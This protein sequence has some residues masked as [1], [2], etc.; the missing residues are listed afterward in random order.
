M[1]T[2]PLSN[3]VYRGVD[4]SE[5]TDQGSRLVNAYVDSLGAIVKRPGL[6]VG[7]SWTATGKTSVDGLYYWPEKDALY[8]VYNGQMYKA[9]RA[10]GV[11][12]IASMA[13]DTINP[14]TRV[15]FACNGSN[16]FAT[17]GGDIIHTNGSAAP[18]YLKT[19]RSNIPSP[20]SQVAWLD[21]YLLAIKPSLKSFYWSNVGDSFTWSALSYA[22]AVGRPDLIRA[23]AVKGTDLYLLGT[24]SIEIWENDGTTPFVRATSGLVETGVSAAS[25]VL[26]TDYGIL[27]VDDK[28]RIVQYDGRDIARV[29]KPIDAELSSY[30]TLND[31]MTDK[32][33]IDG[34]EFAA[35]TFPTEEKT[36]LYDLGG[37]K[38]MEFLA[39]SSTGGNYQ[40]WPVNNMLTIPEW[41]CT[42]AGA[43]CNPYLYYLSPTAHA[44][45][46]SE[47]RVEKT[48]GHIDYGT[49]K[50]KL[51]NQIRLKLK[52]GTNNTIGRAAKVLFRWNDDNKGW[53]SWH[54]ID[55]GDTGDREIVKRFYR[56]GIYRT[57][58]YQFVFTDAVP[59]LLISGEE[60]V[61]VLS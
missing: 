17:N 2:I 50:R 15:S 21:S 12:S 60:D 29:S 1:P 18:A 33:S 32:V 26:V 23:I 16:L 34:E 5:L 37:K 8:F 11:L 52:R 25:S 47:I 14:G 38:W 54:E 36:W 27:F 58:Q 49:T 42:I 41:N 13:G 24:H 51:S 9:T 53:K 46:G 31:V 7:G 40:R 30:L 35:F 56:T 48:T 57:R 28:R 44:D 20:V 4:D 45:N 39:W 10:S 22:S 55:L 3:D 61:E 43:L 59:S 6:E 19:G